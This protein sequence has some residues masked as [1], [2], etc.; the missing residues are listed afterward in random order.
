MD[1]KPDAA[2]ADAWRNLIDES[3]EPNVSPRSGPNAMRPRDGGAHDD[4]QHD[5]SIR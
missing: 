3:I 5:P 4:E 2:R 1:R